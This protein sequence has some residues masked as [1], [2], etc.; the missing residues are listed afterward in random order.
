VISPDL[1]LATA[2]LL[3]D[4]GA[5]A[6]A[7][8]QL[9]ATLAG[10][11][12]AA[13]AVYLSLQR[14]RKPSGDGV[15]RV[16]EIAGALFLSMAALGV[17]S[18]LYGSAAG[19]RDD[20]RAAVA[21]IGDGMALGLSVLALFYTLILM[22]FSHTVTNDGVR[23]AY[24]VVVI[25]GPVVIMRFLIS[26]VY[27]AW[28]IGCARHAA[29][30][31]SSW[32]MAPGWVGFFLL[33]VLGVASWLATWRGLPDRWINWR[34]VQRLRRRPIFPAGLAFGVTFVWTAT[35]SLWIQTRRRDFVVWQWIIYGALVTSVLALALFS[36]SCGVALGT[37]ADVRFFR[38]SNPP[39]SPK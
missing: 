4:Q 19:E 11:A 32:W 9:A 6:Q 31:S 28:E 21:L 10:F 36:L 20:G 2:P 37:R 27:E 22:M 30:A 17:C 24:W 15:I 13:L 5:S 23:H 39:R 18:F 34:L 12:F 33:V 14:S 26:P 25:A 35:A 1:P 29:C 16:S 38:R 3:P 8:S 7:Y